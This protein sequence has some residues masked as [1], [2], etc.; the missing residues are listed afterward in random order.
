MVTSP[1]ASADDPVIEAPPETMIYLMN[2]MERKIEPTV[3]PTV[4][5]N[6]LFTVNNLGELIHMRFDFYLC[7]L[8]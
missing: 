1:N 5:F 7:H 4:Q 3:D 6:S 8:W 2:A